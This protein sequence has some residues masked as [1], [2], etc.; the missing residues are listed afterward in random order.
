M[1]IARVGG[2]TACTK[3]VEDRRYTHSFTS[4]GR[5]THD[6]STGMKGSMSLLFTTPH[7]VSS[8]A[9]AAADTSLRASPMNW[10]S[11]GMISGM[12]RL[13]WPGAERANSPTSDS[14]RQRPCHLYFC[15]A[16]S[17]RKGS[18]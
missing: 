16:A 12:A 18:A 15:A 14:A 2:S 3:V 9:S 13:V 17:N 7:T 10:D 5:A 11:P 4:S 8:D 1:M 6:T